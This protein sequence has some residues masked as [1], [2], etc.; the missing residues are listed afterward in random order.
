MAHL[1]HTQPYMVHTTFQYGG[2]QGKRHRLREG[3][4][5]EDADEYYTQPFLHFELDL[6]RHLV[7]PHGSSDADAAGTLDFAR[8]HTV[9]EHFA[10]VHHQLR[11][12]RNGLAL[13]QALGRVLI[14][15]RLV[16]GLDRWWAPHAGTIPGSA[17]RLPL[18]ECPADHVID[19][20]RMAPEKLLREHSLLCNPRTPA[21][22]LAGAR[23]FRVRVRLRVRVR[24][25]IRFP[26]LTLALALA[27][28]L[29]RRALGGAD[30]AAQAGRGGRGRGG[31]GRGGRGRV[32][33]RPRARA[34]AARRARRHDG[35]SPSPSPSRN[36]DPNPNP[37]QVLELSG[38]LPDYRS[39]LP[40]A[41]V[42]DFEHRLASYASLWCCNHPPGGRGAGHIWYDFLW[43][44]LPHHDRHN[45]EWKHAWTPVMGP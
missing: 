8:R 44:I 26:T 16:C 20:E 39:V 21:R 32:R 33:R 13:A 12:I 3:M 28:T 23:P 4:M 31:R 7:Y 19:L 42:A 34:T 40:A 10:L 24:V 27:L 9:A 45:R 14:L 35:A 2:V 29:T 18:L 38:P 15:P 41:E 43:D 36:R 37:Y 30:C 11:Q 1:M 5:W 25:R 17:T 6:P 22:V